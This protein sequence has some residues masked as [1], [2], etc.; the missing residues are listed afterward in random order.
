MGVCVYMFE[1]VCTCLNV[2]VTVC[3]SVRTRLEAAIQCLVWAGDLV[4]RRNCRDLGAEA[5]TTIE[6]CHS[7]CVCICM[8]VCVSVR[9]RLEASDPMSCLGRSPSNT[10][11]L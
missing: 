10:Q 1:C 9:T 4:T 11:E 2:C 7:V 8:Y 5:D 6:I 3:V